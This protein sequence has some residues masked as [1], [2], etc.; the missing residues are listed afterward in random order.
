V[1]NFYE[2][3]YDYLQKRERAYII[4]WKSG[5]NVCTALNRKKG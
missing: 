1:K 3:A 2:L 4:V 5:N